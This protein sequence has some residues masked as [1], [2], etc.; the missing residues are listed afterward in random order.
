MTFKRKTCQRAPTVELAR[1]AADPTEKP[2]YRKAADWA[3]NHLMR[4]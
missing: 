4:K 1:I 2:R 3:L